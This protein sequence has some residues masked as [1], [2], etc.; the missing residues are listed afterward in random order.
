[1]NTYGCNG[2]SFGGGTSSDLAVHYFKEALQMKEKTVSICVFS[3][4]SIEY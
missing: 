3:T 4:S 1:M 2:W